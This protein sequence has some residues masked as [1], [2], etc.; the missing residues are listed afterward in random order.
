[1]SWNHLRE[2]DL[3]A[4]SDEIELRN[5]AVTRQKARRLRSGDV[6]VSPYVTQP[7][8]P[9]QA[10]SVEQDGKIRLALDE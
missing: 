5:G 9:I 6:E 7:G 8:D 2:T 10:F 3:Y 1:M 4:V